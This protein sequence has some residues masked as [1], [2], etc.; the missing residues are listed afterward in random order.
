MYS[1]VFRDSI[2]LYVISDALS[3]MEKSLVNVLPLVLMVNE[4][5]DN[6]GNRCYF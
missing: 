6:D 2:S 3:V 1:N 5:Y 4:Y